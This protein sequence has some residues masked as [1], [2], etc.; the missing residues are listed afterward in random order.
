MQAC[1]AASQD[2][3]A[4]EDGFP[5]DGNTVEFGF[6]DGPAQGGRRLKAQKMAKKAKPGSFGMSSVRRVSQSINKA[7]KS[8]AGLGGLLFGGAAGREC[9]HRFLLRQE[10][11]CPEGMPLFAAFRS[12]SS[13]KL[14]C[15]NAWLA[16]GPK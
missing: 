6:E 11:T 4:A 7:V 3:P 8:C 10:T 16:L 9:I 12:T 2:Q 5:T 13:M 1:L 15:L 14:Y